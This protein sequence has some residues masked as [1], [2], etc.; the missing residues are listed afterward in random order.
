MPKKKSHKLCPVCFDLI[1]EGTRMK[2]VSFL[3]KKP[4]NATEIGR[5]FALTQPTISHHLKVLKK[6]KM[7]LSQKKGREIFYTLNRAY[8]CNRCSLFQIPFKT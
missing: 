8:P 5:H 4:S 6:N 7:V 1:G 3:K 2:I